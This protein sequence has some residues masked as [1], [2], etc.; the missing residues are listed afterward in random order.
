VIT[1]SGQGQWESLNESVGNTRT[2]DFINKDTGWI[3]G[4]KGIIQ[5][6]DGGDSWKFINDDTDWSKLDFYNDST[7]WAIR[8]ES[9]FHKI[10]KTLDGGQTWLPQDSMTFKL[11]NIFAATEQ[12]IYV[13]GEKL[14]KTM[15]GGESWSDRT[16]S[17]HFDAFAAYFHNADTGFVFTDSSRSYLGQ[18]AYE[19]TFFRTFDGGEAWDTIKVPEFDYLYNIQIANDS[20]VFFLASKW[21]ELNDSTNYFICESND[22]FKSWS[23]LNESDHRISSCYFLDNQNIISVGLSEESSFANIMKSTDGALTWNTAEH[24]PLHG[25]GWTNE[26]YSEEQTV[27]VFRY[28]GALT[29][30]LKSIDQGDHWTTAKMTFPINDLHFMNKEKGFTAG[31]FNSFHYSWNALFLTGDGGKTWKI[32]LTPPGDIS[33]IHFVN[34]SK[35]FISGGGVYTTSDD[36]NSWVPD[37]TLSGGD[38][39]YFLNDSVGWSI[40]NGNVPHLL[41]TNDGGQSWEENLYLINVYFKTKGTINSLYYMDENKGFGVGENGNIVKFSGLNEFEKVPSGTKLPLN[42]VKF[43]GENF[44]MIT[45]GYSNGDGFSPLLMRSEDGGE[46]WTEI[47][48][49][50]YWIHDFHF[51]DS[52]HGFAVGEDVEEKGIILE[53]FDRGTTWGKVAFD[54]NLSDPLRALSFV[55]GSGWAVG[56]N[57]LI[58]KYSSMNTSTPEFSN[59]RNEYYFHNYPNPFHST[60]TISYQLTAA[61]FT[62]LH[63]YD[64]LG[65]CVSTLVREFQPSGF[66]RAKWEP[67]G[68]QPGIYICELRTSDGRQV[69]MMILTR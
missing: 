11:N 47:Q 50:P 44:G 41:K 10:L 31:G 29:L 9:M 27:Y 39:L 67:A 21:N 58:L 56:Y 61:G 35:L 45:G 64:M 46:K 28:N 7:G 57:G 15:D 37:P 4:S 3:A 13:D 53:S 22:F 33:D 63:I 14:I 2:F 55:D 59:L 5:T 65:R 52:L 12:I 24:M 20:V 25:V 8:N 19:N 26:I 23:V 66:H 38:V 43:F 51:I 62:E 1:L 60:T 17:P 49:V 36:G 30:L 48:D 32:V 34:E 16:P 54:R 68:L 42:K 40:R 6:R 18:V 69:I